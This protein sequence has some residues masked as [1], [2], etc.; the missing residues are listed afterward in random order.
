MNKISLPIKP[1][2][3]AAAGLAATIPPALAQQQAAPKWRPIPEMIVVSANPVKNWQGLL[4]GTHFTSA[5]S[6]SASLSV[7]YGDLNLARTPDADEL[8][9]RINVAA[10]LVCHQLDLK[11]PETQYPK[12]AG[13]DCFSGAVQDGLA[14][15]NLIIAAA[16]K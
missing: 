3:L 8:D 15:A 6:V 11:Y 7:P 9:R 4:T 16:R 5:L 10:G 1:L 13:D 12:L 14:R 2:L